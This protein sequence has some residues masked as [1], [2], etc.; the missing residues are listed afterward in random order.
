MGKTILLVH[1]RGIKPP[2]KELYS[3]LRQALAFGLARDFPLDPDLLDSAFVDF[4]YYGDLSNALFQKKN[5]PPPAGSSESHAVT[6]SR[7]Q[8]YKADEFTGERY[9]QVPGYTRYSEA[10]AFRIGSIAKALRLGRP[11]VELYAPDMRQYWNQDSDYGTEVRGRLLGHVL[12]ALDRGDRLCVISHSM[13]T[14]TAWDIFWKISRSGEYKERCGPG[15]KIDLWITVGSPLGDTAIR[16]NLKGYHASGPRRY[17]A[18]IRRWQNIWAEDDYI[19]HDGAIQEDYREM[20][21]AGL[22]E[23]V[24]DAGIYNL[25][26]RDGRSD[27]HN[28]I[29]VIA[30]YIET[31]NLR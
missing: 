10:L 14:M 25:A 27:P 7:L 13:G 19:C 11:Y 23:C 28:L 3:I 12:A 31:T 20:T 16:K 17:P 9:R 8:R 15:K 4:A 26:M 29:E 6:L 1:G 22:T 30:K 24:A 2:K 18:N 5:S 21:E